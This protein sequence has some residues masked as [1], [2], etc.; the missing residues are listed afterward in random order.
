MKDKHSM[1]PISFII[2]RSPSSYDGNS[3]YD[4]TRNRYRFI[5]MQT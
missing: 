1:A 3:M 5:T 4:E 2:D